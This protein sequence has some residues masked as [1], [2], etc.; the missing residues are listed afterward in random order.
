MKK[1]DVH[2]VWRAQ[3]YEN[4]HVIFFFCFVLFCFLFFFI[5]T[6]SKRKKSTVNSYNSIVYHF[7]TKC[8]GKQP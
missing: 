5:H 4:V 3:P 2:I 8:K 7:H 1:N 6:A